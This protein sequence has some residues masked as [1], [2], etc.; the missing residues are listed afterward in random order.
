MRDKGLCRELEKQ[1][2]GRTVRYFD[3]RESEQK[4]AFLAQ[5]DAEAWLVGGERVSGEELDRFPKLRLISKYGVGIDN[6]DFE[7]CEQRKVEVYWEPGV[8]RDAVAEHCIGLMLAMTRK[9]AINSRSLAQG[10]WVKNGGR[11]LGAMK[12]GIVGLG[13]IGKRVA[14]I[15]KAF[16]CEIRFCDIVDK[17]EVAAS[18]GIQA[19]SYEDLLAWADL[20][21][22]HVPLTQKTY[23][24]FDRRAIALA[25]PGVFVVN[26]SRGA[27]IDES[28]LYE[29][30]ESGQVG[31]AGLDVFEIEPL[32]SKPLA[33]HEAL[34]G[35]PHTAGNSLE[36][37]HA[38]G[39][40]AIEGL[41]NG[42]K[43]ADDKVEAAKGDKR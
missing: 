43:K 3:L 19:A 7:A 6:I 21:T 28:A 32:G 12:I 36:A 38:M 35:T 16:G 17:G 8:N 41:K 42:L 11:S 10:I 5:S 25:K 23:K 31:G 26:T 39:S 24:M 13:H 18:L 14:E 1:L 40:A 2:A 37:V 30:L 33:S 27:V 20:I 9:I 29:A 15:V 4:S 34:V 22:F